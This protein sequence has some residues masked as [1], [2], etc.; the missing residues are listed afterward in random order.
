MRKLIAYTAVLILSLSCSIQQNNITSVCG[1]FHGLEDSNQSLSSNN[2]FSYY[3]LL[4]LNED[5]TCSLKKLFDL[6][7]FTGRGEWVMLDDD[8]IEL[9]F[10]DNPELNDIERALIGGG[11][12]EG[13]LE[14]KVLSKNKLQLGNTVLKRKKQADKRR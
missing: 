11:F 7:S 14:V 4:E 2:Q 12:I 9:R 10:N 1:T 13:T 8:M 3:V 6:S 5:H